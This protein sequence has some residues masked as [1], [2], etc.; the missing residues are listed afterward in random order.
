MVLKETKTT[1]YFLVSAK[2]EKTRKRN[3]IFAPR[4]LPYF[5]KNS[6]LAETRK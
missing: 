5:S 1:G 3:W 6:L 4:L 2:R